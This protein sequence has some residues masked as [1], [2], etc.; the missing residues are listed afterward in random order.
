[1]QQKLSGKSLHQIWPIPDNKPVTFAS[2]HFARQ[3]L[4]SN[5]GITRRTIGRMPA[6]VRLIAD[7]FAH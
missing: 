4:R 7:L 2:W 6:C 3:M 1:M 5:E